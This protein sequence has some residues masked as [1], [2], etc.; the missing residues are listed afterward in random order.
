MS[1]AAR[2]NVMFSEREREK[3]NGDLTGVTERPQPY[4][5]VSAVLVNEPDILWL[6]HG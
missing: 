4:A 3:G 6:P 1:G 5:I 2:G